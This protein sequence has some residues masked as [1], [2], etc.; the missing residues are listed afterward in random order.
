MKDR[1]GGLTLAV[2]KI[3]D[4]TERVF[5]P[6]WSG[7]P[8]PRRDNRLMDLG[9]IIPAQ[10][11]ADQPYLTPTADG[12]LLCLVTTGTGHEGSRGQHVVSMKSFDGG[13]TWEDPV[14]VEDPQAPESSWGIPL[15]APGGRI[16]VFYVH[17]ADDLRELA[18]DDP[19]YPGGKT[20][21]MDSHGYYVFRWSDDHGKSWSSERG[22]IPIRE[23]AIDRGNPTGGRIRLFWNVGKAFLHEGSLFLPVH[24]VG[25]FGEGWFTS[26]EGTLVCSDDLLTLEN[27][28]EANWETFPEG[29]IGIR[30][31]EGGG[32]IAEE[33]SFT[34]LDDGSFFTVFRT[35]DGYPAC[36]YSRDRGRSW[37]PSQYMCYADGR[38]IKNPRAANF[39]WKLPDGGYLYWFHNHGGKRLREHPQRRT[40]SYTGRN[41]V[42]F[43]RGWEVDGPTGRELRWSEP[44]IGLYHDDPLIRMSYPD[45]H[46]LDD[47]TFLVTETQKAMARIHRLDDSVKAALSADYK[48]RAR[49][50]ETLHAISAWDRGSGVDSLPIPSLPSFVVRDPLPPYGGRRTREGFSIVVDLFASDSIPVLLAGSDEDYSRFQLQWTGERTLRIVLRD[51]ETEVAWESDPVPGDELYVRFVINI[52]GGSNTI[53]FFRNGKFNDGEDHRDF[54]WGRISPQFRGLIADRGEKDLSNH[55]LNTGVGESASTGR[56]RFP[57]TPGCRIERIE[58]YGR[59]LTAAEVVI[60]CDSEADG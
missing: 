56:I 33:H 50:L 13:Q 10:F 41:P 29:E 37:E 47:G 15:T 43:C 39:A 12:G 6:M 19:P 55:G 18:A 24:K 7:I 52:D 1:V 11:Y 31:P 45:F 38:P 49:A 42:W 23:F 5:D 3:K 14:P 53:C 17:N 60:V 16:F 28:L 9:V 36:A 40:H 54:G 58:F 44:E 51:G 32:P 48:V 27:P 35:I 22:V 57:E 26:S 21:R 59:I 20:Q 46:A 4:R 34:V 2:A 25:G 8:E 30:S